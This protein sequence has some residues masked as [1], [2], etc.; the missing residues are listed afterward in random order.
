LNSSNDVFK[1]RYPCLS[2]SFISESIFTSLVKLDRLPFLS[3]ARL[4]GSIRPAHLLNDTVNH[5]FVESMF[6]LS[7]STICKF[8]GLKI[9]SSI[10]TLPYFDQKCWIIFVSPLLF[11]IFYQNFAKNALNLLCKNYN[12]FHLSWLRRLFNF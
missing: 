3:I 7:F 4:A 11:S 10:H 5:W 12:D 8:K 2:S 1:E 9:S 6:L